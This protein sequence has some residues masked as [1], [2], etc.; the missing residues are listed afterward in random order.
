MFGLDFRKKHFLI[1]EKTTPVNHGSYGLPPKE[2][3]QA[4]EQAFRKDNEYPDR[5]IKLEQQK[6]YRE[7]I[8]EIGKVINSEPENLA[9]VENSTTGINTV[10]RLFRF[11][12]GD[13]IAMPSTTYGACANTVRFLSY[14]A[15]IE[16]VVVPIEYP[17]LD[18]AVVD[19]WKRVFEKEK[20]KLALFDAVVSMPGVTVPWEQL[21]DLCRQHG[22]I[23]LVDAAHAIGLIPLDLKKAR[24]DFFCTNL[25]KWLYVPRGCAVLYVDP[26]FHREIQTLPVSHSYVPP[27]EKLSPEQE[28]DLMLSKFFFNGL[29]TFAAVSSVKAAL[30]FRKE[31]CGGEENI[32]KYCYGLARQVGQLAVAKLPAQLIENEE[33]SL[34]NAMV[35]VFVDLSRY[36]KNIHFTDK[37]ALQFVEFVLEWQL[38]ER[39]TFVPTGFHCGKLL[40]R[41][42]CQVYNFIEEYEYACAALDGAIKAYYRS[43]L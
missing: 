3:V 19:I 9:F 30:K 13:K 15:G 2:V 39:N 20:P 40:A 18:A 7:A 28:K 11:K 42:S 43:K 24:P 36:G 33:S 38:R 14:Y 12:K 25:H 22:V 37:A 6:E 21:V 41:F 27:W 29:R 8:A 17:L 16:I 32:N 26:K 5:Y 23:S 34:S 35:S 4:Y 1:P 31:V 10:L